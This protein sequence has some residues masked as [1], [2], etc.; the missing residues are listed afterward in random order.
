MSTKLS[1]TTTNNTTITNTANAE[2][3]DSDMSGGEMFT[4]AVM[5]L[6][7]LASLFGNSLVIG[8]AYIRESLRSPSNMLLVNLALADLGQGIIAI[9]LRMTEIFNR[10]RQ[11]KRQLN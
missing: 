8:A 4:L 7:I 2:G 5:V 9:P 6:V 11:R 1:R 3:S 10:G